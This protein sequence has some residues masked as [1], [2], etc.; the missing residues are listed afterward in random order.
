MTRQTISSLIHRG[1]KV[2][3]YESFIAKAKILRGFK[4]EHKLI[5]NDTHVGIEV[6]VERIARRGGFGE[7]AEGVCVWNNVEDGSLRNDGREFVSVPLKGEDISFA[8]S[9]LNEHFTK[10]KTCIAHE[11]TDRTSVHVHINVLDF[12]PEEYVNFILTYC[13]VEPLLYGYAGGDRAKNIFC[14]PVVES[15]LSGVLY[16]IVNE[17]VSGNYLNLFSQ[18]NNWQKY[19]GLN[20]KPTTSYGT[21]EFRHMSGTKDIT[22]LTTWINLI[23]SIKKYAKAHSLASLSETFINLNT[24]SEYLG[25]LNSIFG[26]LMEALDLGVAEQS[27][28]HT[29]TFLKDVLVGNSNITS[30]KSE[31]SNIPYSDFENTQFIKSAVKEGLIKLLNVDMM[32]EQLQEKI[33]KVESTILMYNKD[34]AKYQHAMSLSDERDKKLY[35]SYLTQYDDAI[36]TE[37]DKIT[38]Y[39]QQIEDLRAPKKKTSGFDLPE[40]FFAP[41]ANPQRIIIEDF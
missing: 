6:E 27:L 26:E 3:S 16:E 39:L 21:I 36:K 38:S 30:V 9:L 4:P 25:T 7:I 22:R 13:L 8:L 23:L 33:G 35:Q 10:D 31:I 2:V 18:V 14:V 37:K 19:G 1:R 32:I 11:F 40:A 20:L 28:E 41:R 29:S 5:D 17:F 12:T 34:R 24:T 15:N